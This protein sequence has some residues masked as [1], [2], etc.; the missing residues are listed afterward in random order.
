M[1]NCSMLDTNIHMLYFAKG[2]LKKKESKSRIYKKMKKSR[3]LLNPL[4]LLNRSP[5]KRE[6]HTQPC[7]G[8]VGGK[9]WKHHCSKEETITE[10]TLPSH[11]WNFLAWMPQHWNTKDS[12]FIHNRDWVKHPHNAVTVVK[13][14][15]MQAWPTLSTQSET[16][17]IND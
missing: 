2:W 17:N 15:R 6:C 8:S 5:H 13:P 3:R 9:T 14:V 7:K 11:Y 1:G 10:I 4:F 12:S 16:Q